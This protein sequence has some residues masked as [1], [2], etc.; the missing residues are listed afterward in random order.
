MR[1]INY[2]QIIFHFIATCFFIYSFYSFS[3]IYNIKILTL[4][5][6][7]GSENVLRNSEKF[8]ITIMDI[9]NFSFVTQLSAVLGILTSF[10]I[11]MVISIKNKWS[12]WNSFIVLVLCYTLNRFNLLGWN[13]LKNYISLGRLVNNLLFSFLITGSFLLLIGLIIFFSKFLKN[14]IENQKLKQMHYC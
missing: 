13:Y 9:W 14:R 5:S 6:E 3:A 12:V 10:I 8:G 2:L 1:K 7:N 11:S 4:I